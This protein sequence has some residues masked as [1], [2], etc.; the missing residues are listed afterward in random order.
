MSHDLDVR[1]AKV[2]G[3]K[4]PKKSTPNNEWRFCE[5]TLPN[6]DIALIPEIPKW[7][8]SLELMRE[9]E[10]ELDENEFGKYVSEIKAMQLEK[11][12]KRYRKLMSDIF[13]GWLLLNATAEQKAQAWL[14]VKK[15]N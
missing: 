4:F 8:S 15:S 10:G 5:E 12:N 2:L 9:L 7:S 11:W 1:I 6:G 14:K 3:W 13:I